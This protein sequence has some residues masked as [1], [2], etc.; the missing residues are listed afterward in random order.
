MLDNLLVWIGSSV[1]VVDFAIVCSVSNLNEPCSYPKRPP[2]NMDERIE[3]YTN[4]VQ[5]VLPG[6]LV[7]WEWSAS[8][9]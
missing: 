2:L 8:A 1:G 7:A 5:I 3:G 6:C 4:K 9:L